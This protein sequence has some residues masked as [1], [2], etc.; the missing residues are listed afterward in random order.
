MQLKIKSGVLN[1]ESITMI[2]P[3]DPP[4]VPPDPPIVPP[5]RA[6][7]FDI[8]EA[9]GKAGET[10]SLSVEGGCRYPINGFHIGGGCGKE[11]VQGSGYGIFE[12]VGAHLGF[13]LRSYLKTK[14]LIHDEPMHQHDHFWSTFQMA[15]WEP[16]KALPEEWWDFAIGFFSL[17]LAR[18]PMAT[19]IPS[20]TELFTL[21]VKILPGTQPGEYEVTCIDEWYYTQ[22]H[23]RRRDFMYTAGLE[24]DFA[25]GG[26][27]NIETF[28]GKITVTA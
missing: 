9:T 17:D 14:D 5:A 13:F 24:S 15:K 6:P 19:T 18:P 16:S 26:V 8:G 3:P 27:T 2:E 25:S 22:S 7:Y 12:A 23:Q 11:E 4:I 20:G 28:G 10:V 21:E 1:V